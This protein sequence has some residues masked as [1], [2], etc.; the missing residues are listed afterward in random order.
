MFKCIIII[1]ANYVYY[2]N[3]NMV[4]MKRKVKN[5]FKNLKNKSVLLTWGFSYFVFILIT[6]FIVV[7]LYLATVNTI[8]NEI[9]ISNNLLLNNMQS[10]ID[11]MIKN[12]KQLSNEIALNKSI[13]R[14]QYMEGSYDTVDSYLLYEANLALNN[15][16][17]VNPAIRNIYIYYKKNN[18]VLSNNSVSDISRLYELNF[19]NS[20]ISNEVIMDIFTSKF[21]TS[22]F[23]TV[24]DNQ[25]YVFYITSYPFMST[26][27]NYMTVV[28]ELNKDN[29][30]V[31][32]DEST[33]LNNSTFF[34]LSEENQLLA[35]S[36]NNNKQI[37][38]ISYSDLTWQPFYTVRKIDNI[39][40][41]IAYKPSNIV[42][43][44][45]VVAMPEK[46]FWQHSIALF[47]YT[48]ISIFAAIL[49]G[50]IAMCISLRYNY[51]PIHDLLKNMEEKF[52]YHF[53]KNLNEYY[54]IKH[55]IESAAT[56]HKENKLMLENQNKALFSAMLERIIKGDTGHFVNMKDVLF[57][58]KLDVDFENYLLVLFYIEGFEYMDINMSSQEN[59]NLLKEY[60]LAKFVLDNVATEVISSKAKCV[61]TEVD[62]IM[63]YVVNIQ[64]ADSE[65]IRNDM[66]AAVEKIKSFI[67]DHFDFGITT[68]ISK[69]YH[70]ISTI[71][72]CFYEVLEVIE[73][74]RILDSD[75]NLSDEDINDAV[76]G[77]QL[78]YPA[79][80]EYQ[81]IQAVKNY[82]WN[83][84]KQIIEDLFKRNININ[85][86]IFELHFYVMLAII[87]SLVKTVSNIKN[88]SDLE[89]LNE[90][91]IA[92][93]I[94]SC[95][96]PA[97]IKSETLCIA[98][99][100]I[101]SLKKCDCSNN[102]HESELV[103]DI[104]KYIEN[105]YQ[106]A[107][108]SVTNIADALN[109]NPVQMSRSFRNIAGETLPNY[110]NKLRIEHAK[111]IMNEGYGNLE[112]LAL[113]VGFSNTKTL[114][115]AF[116][117]Y[118]GISPGSYNANVSM[119][120]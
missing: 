1:K 5:L 113:K 56:E 112:E 120:K 73:Y 57:H 35:L 69:P 28:L 50:S 92:K 13:G 114:T 36:Q 90:M 49:L 21:E 84:T 103:S 7:A 83:S 66:I 52:G 67:D 77:N 8:R 116:K 34:M 30:F 86:S 85:K 107:D 88:T 70:D 17:L 75:S 71:S 117:K 110:I 29:F 45:Y 68:A 102:N 55:S 12:A 54:F 81:L 2:V 26:N 96:T 87:S 65:N 38:D 31:H 10:Q 19:K 22:K 64:Q 95:N 14:L 105:N 60:S 24:Q 91:E 43:W 79:Q 109:Q 39:N 58:S 76:N 41:V 89:I 106:N 3:I 47:K 4:F 62:N 51:Y 61:S 20:N 25:D 118:M 18:I 108:L 33:K 94:K 9:T 98:K 100:I 119:K 97:N 53:S 27:N 72:N 16:F 42:Q 23:M 80:K 99:H 59:L 78:Y 6:I 63:V 101:N 46:I 40:T 48:A 32:L 74:K 37:N 111:L 93:R 15:Y 104:V 115:R 44:K 11:S 82:D